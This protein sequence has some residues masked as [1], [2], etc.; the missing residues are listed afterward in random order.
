MTKVPTLEER[1]DDLAEAIK[2]DVKL[3]EEETATKAEIR[4]L[5]SLT[6]GIN[7]NR[8]ERRELIASGQRPG[9]V[10][11]TKTAIDEL[12]LHVGD[13][14]WARKTLRENIQKIRLREGKTLCLELKPA[15]DVVAK[16]HAAALVDVYDTQREMFKLE[17]ELRAQDISFFP[18][19]CNLET[20][21]V[22]GSVND[23]GSALARLLRECVRYGY[24]SKLPKGLN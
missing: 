13:L 5:M 19:V 22:L 9:P 2:L 11:N 12:R 3:S 16:R 21:L 4:R 14:E 15:Y 18:T 17:S 10:T 8:K 6:S 23:G 20:E 24:L 1:S 7:D